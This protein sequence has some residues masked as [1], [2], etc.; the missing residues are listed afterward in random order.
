MAIQY[1]ENGLIIQSLLEILGEREE[2]CK[3]IFDNDFKISGESAVA[4]L[5]SADADREFSLQ[6]LLLYIAS[7]LDPDQAEGIW[8]DYICALNNITRYNATKSTIPIKITGTI[9]T[10]KNT[11]EVTIVDETTDEY[12][13]NQNA[14]F[15]GED[16]IANVTFEATS[17][18]DITALASSN[19]SL[20]TP[21]VGINEITYNTEGRA[22]IGRNT[23]T[24]E[25]LR[26]R[27]AEAVTYTASSI[28]S[29]IRAAVSQL[30]GVIYINAYENDT[31][32]T[33][34]TLPPKSFE[35]VVQGGDDTEITQAIL[36]K[37]QQVFKHTELLQKP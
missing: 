28:L 27:R 29:S 14:F 4:N 18:G 1:D 31:M 36:Q 21:S 19:F 23:E 8:L 12:Y 9:G 24:D 10:A 13:T 22:T 16:G 35:V 37:N 30:S 34:D 11:G 3:Q 15:I 26:L 33:V 17:Y 32:N 6:E 20:K 25:E 5:Q 2:V 7:Q